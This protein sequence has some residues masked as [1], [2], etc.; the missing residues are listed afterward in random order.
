MSAA[1]TVADP[2]PAEDE[3]YERGLKNR[4]IQMIA[5][6]GA[7]GTGLFFG[8]GTAITKA[9]PSLIAAYLVAGVAIFFVMRALGELLMYRP[10]AGSFADYAREFLGPFAGFATGWT[11]WITWVVTGMAELTAAGKYVAYWIDI[12]QWVTALVVLLVLFGANLISVKV[13]GE[14]E[15]WFSMIKVTAIIGMILLGLGVLIFG[16]SDAG[17]TASV[18]HLWDDGG[19]A[20]HG[21]WQ[22]L[23][24]LQVVMFA[25]VGV[26][27]IGV[28]ASEAEDPKTMLPRA[29]NTVPWRIGLFYIGSLVVILAMVEWRRFE[30]N[31]SPFVLAFDQVG[32]GAAAGIVNFILLTAALSSCNSGLYSTGRMIRSLSLSQ[33]APRALSR[34]SRRHV[35]A[36]GIAL[37]V[38]VMAI[39]VI[40]NALVPA[41]AFTYITSVATVGILWVWGII[42]VSHWRYRRAVDVGRL[43]RS[44]FRMPGAPWTG[45]VSLAFLVFVLVLLGFDADNRVA[46]YVAPAW[47]L[48]L[49]VGYRWTTARVAT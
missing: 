32:I 27:L 23:L 24:V 5:I 31:T 1:A 3:G 2:A 4:Q 49:L 10:V 14:A 42:L 47:A 43:P 33:Q 45:L 41:K 11:Y 15:F 36:G 18:A 34:L 9:G 26:E 30:P 28:T 19:F 38:A 12:P 7:I 29:I 35:P 40:V 46:L 21:I 37:S 8:A 25:Y 48:A 17:D 20:P 16:F 44:S 39:G 22:T 13:F 6:G